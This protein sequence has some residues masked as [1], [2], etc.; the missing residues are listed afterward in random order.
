MPP[1]DERC[2][3]ECVESSKCCGVYLF[4]EIRFI[5]YCLQNRR[6]EQNI[7]QIIAIDITDDNTDFSCTI[8]NVT[9]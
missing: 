5:V 2:T 1:L 3:A 9:M 4:K 6:V 7:T 8:E